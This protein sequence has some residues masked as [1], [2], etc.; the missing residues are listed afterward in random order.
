MTVYRGTWNDGYGRS[1]AAYAVAASTTE[2]SAML[3]TAVPK[4]SP[5]RFTWSGEA[6][7]DDPYLELLPDRSSLWVVKDDGLHPTE[8]TLE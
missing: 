1:G 7:L 5:V 8:V 6:D 2:R 3:A 4:D